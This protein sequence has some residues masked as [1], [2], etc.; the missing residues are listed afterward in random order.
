[1]ASGGNPLASLPALT[2]TP[3]ASPKASPR[4]S[5]KASPMARAR[6]VDLAESTAEG[7]MMDLREA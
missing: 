1:M 4:A 7:G 3:K 6:S 5:P 2:T